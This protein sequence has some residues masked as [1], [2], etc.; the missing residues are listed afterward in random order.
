M[1]HRRSF[2]RSVR[3]AAFLLGASTLVLSVRDARANT[4][5]PPP[6]TDMTNPA[7]WPD[8]PGYTGDWNFWS[9][10][11]KQQPNTIP[12]LSADVMRGASGMSIDVGWTYTIGDPRVKI[13]IIDSGI[14]WDQAD[15]INK[16]FLNR[17]ELSKPS[18][19]P[20]NAMGQPCGG[21]GDLAGYDC[22]GDGVFTM[23]DYANDPR[24]TPIVAGDPCFQGSNPA[25]PGADRQ[26][27]DVN[28]NRYYT[29]P[30]SSAA[31]SDRIRDA[32]N[33]PLPR[34]G[35]SSSAERIVGKYCF[36]NQRSCVCHP[37]LS[38]LGEFTARRHPTTASVNA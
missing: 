32:W 34:G 1:S 11:P 36:T 3:A 35:P 27:G 12:Y 23:N 31:G 20:Q 13:A 2:L 25:T 18:Q 5:P 22:D 37:I 29:G 26:M 21:S 16:A 9:F 8:D 24:M 33:R 28:H 17:G 15:L 4:W 30:A 10:L 7:N 38:V 6:G 14:E 19:M